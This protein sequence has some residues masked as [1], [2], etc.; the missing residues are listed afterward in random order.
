MARKNN[1]MG[2]F[3]LARTGFGLGLGFAAVNMLLIGVALLLFIPGFIMLNK[4]QKKPKE[5]QNQGTKIFAFVL[6]GLGVVVGL[7]FGGGALLGEIG[8]EL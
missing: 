1:G 5:E 2:I 7:G 8:E 3:S 4:E 6:M